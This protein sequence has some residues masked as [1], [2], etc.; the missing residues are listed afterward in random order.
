MIR[1]NYLKFFLIYDI[2]KQS[3][4]REPDKLGANLEHICNIAAVKRISMY[5]TFLIEL[6]Y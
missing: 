6:W 5:M 3:N 2:G 4:L 1:V